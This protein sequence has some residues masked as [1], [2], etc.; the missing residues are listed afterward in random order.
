MQF[1]ASKIKCVSVMFTQVGNDIYGR[2]RYVNYTEDTSAGV[3]V[4]FDFLPKGKT[5]VNA[6]TSDEAKG[7]GVKDI[8]ITYSE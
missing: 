8:T 1:Q 4:D 2:V 5:T 7:Y 3:G 6:V